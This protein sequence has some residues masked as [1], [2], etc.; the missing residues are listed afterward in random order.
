MRVSAAAFRTST[1][2]SSVVV[3]VEALEG[4][5]PS[6]V[7]DRQ[8]SSMALLVVAADEK[9]NVKASERGTL[10]IGHHC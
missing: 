4:Q 10:T 2:K 1:S 7:G 5:I 8:E 6:E 9:G 3:V